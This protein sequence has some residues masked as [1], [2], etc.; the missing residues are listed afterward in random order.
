MNTEHTVNKVVVAP[1]WKLLYRSM[2][3]GGCIASLLMFIGG[4][5]GLGIFLA[6]SAILFVSLPDEQRYGAVKR[7]Q[8]LASPTLDRV[9]AALAL[10]SIVGCLVAHFMGA[11]DLAELF[12]DF[13]SYL[14]SG[15]MVLEAVRNFRSRNR[16]G[17]AVVPSVKSGASGEA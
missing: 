11:E 10:V 4:M 7:T 2:I 6:S 3:V 17:A 15:C 16:D 13:G 14:V 12:A 9:M 1:A 5:V 8:K